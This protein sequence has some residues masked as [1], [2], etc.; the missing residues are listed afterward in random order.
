MLFCTVL[1]ACQKEELR[2]KELLAFVKFNGTN[3]HVGN[4]SF[5]RTPISAVGAS[6]ISFRGYLIR[7]ASVGVDL[8]ISVD[9]AKVA[10]YNAKNKTEYAL[11]PAANYLIGGTGKLSVPTG[12][13]AS[14]DSVKIEL[15]DREKLTDPKGYLLPLS[16]SQVVSEDKGIQVSETHGTVY[17]LVNS[18][19]NNIDNS[20]KTPATGTIANRST[21][22][23]SVAAATSPYAAAYAAANVLDGQHGTSWFTRGVNS[24]I[25]LDLAAS[26]TIK[27]FVMAPSYAFGATY[28]AT[29]IEVLISDDNVTWLSQGVYRANPVLS[30]SSAASPDNRNINFY[31]PI[32]CRYV[33]FI[34]A[35]LPNSYGGF[36][37][38]NAIK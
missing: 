26:H 20:I 35:E 13:T 28:N 5:S 33:K 21:P 34:M 17:V 10:L 29:A 11:L 23:W 19:F 6:E 27:G 24:F 12:A 32:T 7:E 38:I 1:A 25:T 31:S 8:S 36:S 4:I 14:L 30:S 2:S 18:V 37:E 15:K 9:E 22:A 16:I 3:A